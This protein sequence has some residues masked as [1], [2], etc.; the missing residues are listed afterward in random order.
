MGQLYM[1]CPYFV[2]NI[3]SFEKNRLLDVI[4]AIEKSR[5]L[6]NIRNFISMQACDVPAS[7][8]NANLQKRLAGD[9]TNTEVNNGV[10]VFIEWFRDYHGR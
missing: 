9:S 3:G 5:N 7:R 10:F 1:G 2:V 4:D 8:V 6:K